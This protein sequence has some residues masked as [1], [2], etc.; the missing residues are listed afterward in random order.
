MLFISG[1]NAFKLRK[2]REIVW[3]CVEFIH[4]GEHE[5]GCRVGEERQPNLAR[6]LQDD[7]KLARLWQESCKIS[8]EAKAKSV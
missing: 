4:Q 7:S 1:Q 2:W 5:L 8:I 3:Q 6:I